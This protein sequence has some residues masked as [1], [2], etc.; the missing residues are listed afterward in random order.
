VTPLFGKLG[1]TEIDHLV[2]LLVD[3]IPSDRLREDWL[4]MRVVIGA[5]RLGAVKPL[6]VY[7][8]Q[9][10]QQLKAKQPTE[11][12]PDGALAMAV[13]IVAVDLHLGTVAQ[14]ALDHGRHLR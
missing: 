4:K 3:Q 1:T 2:V 8:F 10:R 6:T 9:S 14:H 13:D 7:R 12:K 11:C 5:T